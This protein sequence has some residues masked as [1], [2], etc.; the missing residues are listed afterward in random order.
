MIWAVLIAIGLVLLLV[1]GVVAGLFHLV[2]APNRVPPT[3]IE[4]VVL[5]VTGVG[6]L[7]VAPSALASAGGGVWAVPVGMWVVLLIVLRHSAPLAPVP[8][9]PSERKARVAAE[10]KHAD[11]QRKALERKRINALGKD[12]VKLMERATAAIK[13][14]KQTEAA[15][16]GWLGEP[17]DLDFSAEVTAIKDALRQARRIEKL[18]A[19]SKALP[20][21][22]EDDTTMMRDG[23]CTIKQLRGDALRRVEALDD[24][25]HQAR[26]IDRSLA[27]E[28]E[29][30]RVDARRDETRGQ[31]AAELYG[32]EAA[33]AGA[34]WDAADSVTARVAAF[35]ELK[36]LV[37]EPRQP[38][39][40]PSPPQNVLTWLRGLTPF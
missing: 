17:A 15:R 31:L 4:W 14:V 3:P 27:A 39:D 38:V 12:G 22:T 13:A 30:A 35:R 28:R 29:Q 16:G 10:R 2:F 8:E 32:A 21:P 36:G 11:E 19:E 25:V 20:S 1:A 26:Q 5:A 34:A 40:P 9:T 23:E 6:A 33:S 7:I 18:V 24:C 37:D